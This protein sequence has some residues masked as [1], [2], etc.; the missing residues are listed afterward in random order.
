MTTENT[1]TT[2]PAQR[3]ATGDSKPV[4]INMGD[5]GIKL[6]SFEEAFRFAK[7]VAI[8]G[9]APKGMDKPET[10]LVCLQ[11]G[12]ELGFSPMQALQNVTVINGKSAIYGDAGLAL[13][14]GK[15]LLEDMTE[16]WTGTIK[17]GTRCCEITMKRKGQ[18]PIVR[19][20]SIEDARRGGLW[21][22]PGP[23][24]QY[25]ERMLRYRA[26]AFTMRDLFSDVLKGVSIAEEDYVKERNITSEVEVTDP[27]AQALMGDEVGPTLSTQPIPPKER[28]QTAVSADDHGPQSTTPAPT[29]V[30]DRDAAIAELEVLID[31]APASKCEKAAKAVGIEWE[32]FENWPMASDEKLVTM[33]SL[34]KKGKK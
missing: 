5:S 18:T 28:E 34:L 29:P 27:R 9:L 23:W 32:Q 12:L 3:T 33:A 22:K 17:D 14:R 4:A 10:I 8:S 20:F 16:K 13:I 6:Q 21:G 1:Q 15:G 30:F 31:D 11:S 19:S 2:L 24:S 7:Y 25:P 26:L